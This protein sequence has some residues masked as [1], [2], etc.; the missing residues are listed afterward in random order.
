MGSSSRLFISINIIIIKIFSSNTKT[1][2]I[3]KR[4]RVCTR[5]VIECAHVSQ[6][7]W[8]GWAILAL[9]LTT[10]YPNN[11]TIVAPSVIIVIIAAIVRIMVVP[12][13]IHLIVAVLSINYNIIVPVAAVVHVINISL[14]NSIYIKI[15]PLKLY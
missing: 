3:E 6:V 12:H 7:R 2:K 15:E 13:V 10:H 4:F 9:T 14:F 11:S 5:A 8:S 1:T